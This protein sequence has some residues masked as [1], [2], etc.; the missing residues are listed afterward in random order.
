MG[1][2]EQGHGVAAGGAFALGLKQRIEG[3][4]VGLAREQAVAIDEIAQ[5][6]GFASQGVDDVAVIDDMSV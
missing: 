2:R 4:A 6:H 3:A 5:G 1:Q